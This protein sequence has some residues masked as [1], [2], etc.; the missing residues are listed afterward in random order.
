MCAEVTK[1]FFLDVANIY[2][3]KMTPISEA[4]ITYAI[5]TEK[6]QQPA[7]PDPEKKPVGR[8]RK[9]CS[10]LECQDDDEDIDEIKEMDIVES[11]AEDK[12]KSSI[13]AAK[14]Q[15]KLCGGF[16]SKHLKTDV[17]A[18]EAFN[19]WRSHGRVDI[20]P[21]LLP[22]NPCSPSRWQ[23]REENDNLK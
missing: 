12:D 3:R 2:G 16:Q 11:E 19:E 5:D 4:I 1:A 20:P 15:L 17:T 8:K 13:K 22:L 6:A 9:T 23:I 18:I 7:R 21:Q 10:H 14:L